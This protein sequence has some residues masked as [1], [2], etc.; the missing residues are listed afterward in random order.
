LVD[1]TPY[2][3]AV[4]SADMRTWSNVARPLPSVLALLNVVLETVTVGAA[5]S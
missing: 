4:T 1:A 5:R 2:P 3:V